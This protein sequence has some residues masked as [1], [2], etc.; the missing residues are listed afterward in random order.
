[1][2]GKKEDIYHS[3]ELG[4]RETVNG[5]D[6]VVQ[7]E[8]EDVGE[9]ASRLQSQNVRDETDMVGHEN[10]EGSGGQVHRTARAPHTP[11]PKEVDEHELTHCPYRSWCD[12]C[13]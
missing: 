10:I 3:D 8:T 1:M 11:S 7:G 9:M 13:V 12:H 5:M 6:V 4:L 2:K